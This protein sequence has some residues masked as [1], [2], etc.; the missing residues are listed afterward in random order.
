MWS[1]LSLFVVT[2]PC[3]ISLEVHMSCNVAIFRP[4]LF[5]LSTSHC[6]APTYMREN[7]VQGVCFCR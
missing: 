5:V 7:L 1:V 6:N 2:G 3:C 4:L